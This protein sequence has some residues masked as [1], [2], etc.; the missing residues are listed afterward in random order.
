MLRFGFVLAVILTNLAPLP[1]TSVLI[2]PKRPVV[3][4]WEMEKTLPTG[5]SMKLRF[6]L[7]PASTYI[8]GPRVVVPCQGPSEE[9]FMRGWRDDS[10]QIERPAADWWIVATIK[11]AL[12]VGGQAADQL[13]LQLTNEQSRIE[14]EITRLYRVQPGEGEG[15]RAEEQIFRYRYQKMS[16]Y[17]I[18]GGSE[19]LLYLNTFFVPVSTPILESS[20][21]CGSTP[22]ETACTWGSFGTLSRDMVVETP[23]PGVDRADI[24]YIG[25]VISPDMAGLLKESKFEAVGVDINTAVIREPNFAATPNLKW[26]FLPSGTVLVP[27]KGGVQSMITVDPLLLK[28]SALTDGVFEDKSIAVHCLEIDKAPPDSTVTFTLSRGSD[29]ILRNLAMMTARSSIRGPWD[30]A[31]LWIYSDKASLERINKRLALGCPPGMYVRAL[32]EVQT[33]AGFKDKDLDNPDLFA[34]SLL[35]GPGNRKEAVGWFTGVLLARH[36]PA[37]VQYLKSGG[38]EFA[39]LATSSNPLAGPQFLR[40]LGLLLASEHAD[41]RMATL[42]LLDAQDKEVLKKAIGRP[43]L[44]WESH[45]ERGGDEAALAQKLK[46]KLG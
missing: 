20:R 37:L 2:T 39:E 46:D 38:K 43:L 27:G 21:P 4:G 16:L 9:G 19:R 36:R 23:F 25:A 28:S 32:W 29:P 45:L 17:V 42:Q 24:G 35:G 15:P 31:R 40:I 13:L 3:T 22:T 7:R 8:E 41:A 11:G 18:I 14:S 33:M 5:R 12:K 44:N 1:Q 6:E 34:P 30:Q 26:I 10:A